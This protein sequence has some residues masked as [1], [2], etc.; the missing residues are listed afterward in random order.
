MSNDV[1]LVSLLLTLY[2]ALVNSIEFEQVNACKAEPL[3][4]GAFENTGF[5]K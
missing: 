3:K 4:K 1:V 2:I 5:L